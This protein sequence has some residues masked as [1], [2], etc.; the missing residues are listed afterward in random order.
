M[1]WVFTGLM[2]TNLWFF[3][4]LTLGLVRKGAGIEDDTSTRGSACIGAILEGRGPLSLCLGCFL[5][6]VLSNVFFAGWM[7]HI[8]FHSGASF[9]VSGFTL[10]FLSYF[11]FFSFGKETAF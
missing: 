5:F 9:F 7:T 4:W 6:L 1:S 8:L 3:D 11:C 2:I 10:L